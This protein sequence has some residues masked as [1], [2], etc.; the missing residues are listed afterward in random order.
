MTQWDNKNI[1]DKP[2]I[3]AK[4]RKKRCSVSVMV[5]KYIYLGEGNLAGWF[6]NLVMVI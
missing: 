6:P 2:H 4:E 3:V 1:S 5:G